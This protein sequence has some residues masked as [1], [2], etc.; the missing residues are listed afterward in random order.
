[1]SYFVLNTASNKTVGATRE[2]R[3]YGYRTEAAAKA[4]RTRFLKGAVDAPELVV[5]RQNELPTRTV[6]NLMSGEEVEIPINT[7]LSSDP[8]SETYWSM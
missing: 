3:L 1:M 8:S 7:P 6:R 5:V 2:A 4:A